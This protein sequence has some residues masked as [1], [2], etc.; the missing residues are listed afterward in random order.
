MP[1]AAG[2]PFSYALMEA[3]QA[4]VSASA[5]SSC[6]WAS[7]PN[8]PGHWGLFLHAPMEALQVMMSSSDASFCI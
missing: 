7:R 3:L 1:P 4:L 6:I 5:A 8:A 2:R